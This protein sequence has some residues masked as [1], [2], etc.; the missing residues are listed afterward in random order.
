MEKYRGFGEKCQ[1]I[2]RVD[3]TILPLLQ[4]SGSINDDLIEQ[5]DQTTD[6]L[7]LVYKSIPKRGQSPTLKSRLDEEH[8]NVERT[9]EK[10]TKLKRRQAKIEGEMAKVELTLTNRTLDRSQREDL[11]IE[12]QNLRTQLRNINRD[13]EMASEACNQ[14]TRD[15]EKNAYTILNDSQ[16]HE[17]ASLKLIESVLQDFIN[18]LKLQSSSTNGT[19]RHIR[20]ANHSLQTRKQS[21]SSS[22]G[23]NSDNENDYEDIDEDG[24]D[25]SV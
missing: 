7:T 14:V 12:K 5:Y 8:S 16:Q 24:Y 17:K 21:F 10:L 2:Q 9:N 19:T 25:E 6:E 15:Y 22:S 4:A 3:R 1:T 18:A 11:N 20:P 23:T 13:I